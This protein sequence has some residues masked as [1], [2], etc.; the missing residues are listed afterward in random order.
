MLK[1]RRRGSGLKLRL[2]RTVSGR[3]RLTAVVVLLASGLAGF[4]T[5]C[6]LYPR[7]LFKEDRA[8]ASV[9]GKT[10]AEAE[11]ALTRQGF[12]VK[13][14]G[15]APDPE[16]PEGRIL[17]QDPPADLVLPAGATIQLTRSSGPAPVAVPD[18]GEFDL[19][20]ATR[21]I[22]AAGLT[23]GS[24]DSVPSQVDAGVVIS[25]RPGAGAARPPGSSIDVVVS[26]GP[27]IIRVPNVVGL[28]VVE[29][30]QRLLDLGLA[31]GRVT[32]VRRQGPPATVYEQR[33]APGTM[34][35]RGG[36]VDLVV[37]EV[38]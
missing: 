26:R 27:A 33:P 25:T 19:D 20:Y 10:T 6:V 37:S 21:V 16:V 8:V 38:N 4:L 7:P 31:V 28:G 35:A 11:E 32:R 18:V 12:K 36:R 22:A 34:S 9:F 2:P 13:V 15:E 5:T 23:L 3:R 17:W 1:L 24:V 14:E 30:R 29:A